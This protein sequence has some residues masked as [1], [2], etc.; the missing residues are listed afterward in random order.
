MELGDELFTSALR[1]QMVSGGRFRYPG[2]FRGLSAERGPEGLCV[3]REGEC[4]GWK[5]GAGEGGH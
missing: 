2:V 3:G 1:L 4:G 5:A